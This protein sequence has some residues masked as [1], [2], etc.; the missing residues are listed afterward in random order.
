MSIVE[1]KWANT[2]HVPERCPGAAGQGGRAATADGSRL[3]AYGRSKPQ[4]AADSYI[5]QH[6]PPE[7][8]P[9]DDERCG[10]VGDAM[11]FLEI[12]ACQVLVRS[13]KGL[14]S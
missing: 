7:V 6:G 9:A 2:F 5:V 13:G 4:G 11:S 8:I 3:T 1:I 14:R 10:N 12:G